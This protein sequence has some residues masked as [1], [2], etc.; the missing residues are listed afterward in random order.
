M[1]PMLYRE[2]ENFGAAV[3]KARPGQHTELF[4]SMG[5]EICEM[6]ETLAKLCVFRNKPLKKPCK[7]LV[8]TLRKPWAFAIFRKFPQILTTSSRGKCTT[9]HR[10][11]CTPMTGSEKAVKNPRN[12][13]LSACFSRYFREEVFLEM[14]DISQI[15]AAG[16]SKIWGPKAERCPI[17]INNLLICIRLLLGTEIQPLRC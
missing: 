4:S 16:W 9:R 7:N 2:I 6:C 12:A 10:G 1:S 14:Y 11:K 17:F 8:K 15:S 3:Q 13:M 5:F